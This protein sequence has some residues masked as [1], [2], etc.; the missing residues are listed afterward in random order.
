LRAGGLCIGAGRQ[1]L[2][3]P[4]RDELADLKPISFV[5]IC[6][7]NVCPGGTRNSMETTVGGV[8]AR[9]KGAG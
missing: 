8:I 4:S 5:C 7:M 9:E 1:F 6:F 3:L 2:A